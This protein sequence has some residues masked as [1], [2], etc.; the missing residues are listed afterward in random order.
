M[1]SHKINGM[2]QVY[3]MK[4]GILSSQQPENV[5]PVTCHVYDASLSPDRI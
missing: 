2:D 4:V 5:M 1:F 3:F